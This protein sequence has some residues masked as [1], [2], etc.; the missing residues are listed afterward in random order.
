MY[1]RQDIGRL[2]ICNNIC[3]HWHHIRLIV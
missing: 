2:K 1:T 3:Y